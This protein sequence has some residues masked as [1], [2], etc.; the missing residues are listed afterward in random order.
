MTVYQLAIGLTQTFALIAF[1]SLLV[2]F[3]M[4]IYNIE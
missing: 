2:R 3:Y 1:V 4:A